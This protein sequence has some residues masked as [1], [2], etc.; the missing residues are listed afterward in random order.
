MGKEV[1][2]VYGTKHALDN[3]AFI[4]FFKDNKGEIYSLIHTPDGKITFLA[5]TVYCKT[6]HPERYE[7]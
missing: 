6:E 7:N 5:D 3:E 1:S 4:N 2:F